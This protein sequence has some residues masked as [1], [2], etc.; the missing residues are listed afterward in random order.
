MPSCFSNWD[1][2][3]FTKENYNDIT[4]DSELLQDWDYQNTILGANCFSIDEE[5]TL[6]LKSTIDKLPEKIKQIEKHKINVIP[7]DLH[8]MRFTFNCVWV[9]NPGGKN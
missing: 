9:A 5:N 8:V 2:I 3:H 4:Q 7:I 1:F 6:M